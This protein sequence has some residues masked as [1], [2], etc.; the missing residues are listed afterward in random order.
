MGDELN[1]VEIKLSAQAILSSLLDSF[2][3]RERTSLTPRA[4][5]QVRPLATR[6]SQPDARSSRYLSGETSYY[7]L[8]ICSGIRFGLHKKTEIGQTSLY[9]QP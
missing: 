6:L 4:K 3:L 7:L 5:S 2:L 8:I 1:S 9:R